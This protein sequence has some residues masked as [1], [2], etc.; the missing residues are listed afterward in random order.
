MG[1]QEVSKVHQSS[2]DGVVARALAPPTLVFADCRHAPFLFVC[3]PHT[4]LSP[5]H[6]LCLKWLSVASCLSIG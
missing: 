5:I 1:Y 2:M 3:I 4:T 6:L